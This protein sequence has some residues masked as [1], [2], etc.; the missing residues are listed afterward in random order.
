[1]SATSKYLVCE[2]H[3]GR[4]GLLYF[5]MVKQLFEL[6]LSNAHAQTIGAI[7]Y[8]DDSLHIRVVVFPQTA[9]PPLPAHVVDG[10]IYV[11]LRELLYLETHRRSNFERFRL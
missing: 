2:E 5:L 6:F 10:E 4:L 8:E 3:D 11:I 9:V 1:M 7:E